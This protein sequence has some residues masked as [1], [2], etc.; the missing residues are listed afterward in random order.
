MATMHRRAARAM[1][2]ASTVTL[3]LGIGGPAA[4]QSAQDKATAEALFTDARKALELGN[5]AEA[6]PKLASSERLDPAIGTALFLGECYERT[7][8]AASAWAMFREAQ[9]LA[10]KRGDKRE[11]V[12][13]KRADRLEPSKLTVALAPGAQVAGLEIERDG[14]VLSSSLIGF[15]TPLDGGA[16]TLCWS[17][18]DAGTEQ[19]P[20][21]S[22]ARDVDATFGDESACQFPRVFP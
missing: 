22:F 6:C 15:S 11:E 10:H 8:K 5:F 21:L 1:L 3:A 2:I 20:Q 4:A 12:A 18:V 14:V 13:Q 17:L 9:D 7:N 19:V 16:H